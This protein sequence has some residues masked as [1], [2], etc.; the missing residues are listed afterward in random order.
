M[1]G[2][3]PRVSVF[4]IYA[5]TVPIVATDDDGIA[6]LA[7]WWQGEK[8]AWVPGDGPR[9]KTTVELPLSHG[10][11]GLTIVVSDN[12]DNVSQAY[13]KVW[14]ELDTETESEAAAE[15]EPTP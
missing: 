5:V 2:T 4:L 10:S 14:G 7:V 15:A 12:E 8:V 1:K 13:R 9:L 3:L 6:D 11:N